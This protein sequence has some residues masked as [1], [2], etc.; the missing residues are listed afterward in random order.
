MLSWDAGMLGNLFPHSWLKCCLIYHFWV[1]YLCWR[2][3]V[4]HPWK[5][6]TSLVCIFQTDFPFSRWIRGIK[7][8]TTVSPKWKWASWMLLIYS[9]PLVWIKNSHLKMRNKPL[10]DLL[11]QP[12]RALWQ[13]HFCYLGNHLACSCQGSSPGSQFLSPPSQ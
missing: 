9:C 6:M 5:A 11:T 12:C 4:I 1:Q 8:L 3:S 10:R 7:S 13:A 2:N